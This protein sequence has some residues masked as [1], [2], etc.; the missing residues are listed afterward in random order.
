MSDSALGIATG[1]DAYLHSQQRTVGGTAVEE[2]VVRPSFPTDA[3]YSVLADDIST[4]SPNSHLLQVMA[5]GTN[6]CRLL[7]LTIVPTDDAPASD[8]LFKFQVLRLTTAGTGGA[9]INDAPYDD[10]DSYGGDMR[11]L[12]T[13]AGTEGQLLLKGY[14]SM[15]SAPAGRDNVAWVWEPSKWGKPIT[16]GPDATDGIVVKVENAVASAAVLLI[17]EIA[18]TTYL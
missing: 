7:R 6:Y 9:A 10:G 8:A 4:A 1:T 18:V 12:P 16:F 5:D 14:M 2:Q 13:A 17:A 15:D 11:S 3:T